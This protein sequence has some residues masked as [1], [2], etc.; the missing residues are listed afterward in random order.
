MW[1]A[2]GERGENFSPGNQGNSRPPARLERSWKGT[3]CDSLEQ[4][5]HGMGSLLVIKECFSSESLNLVQMSSAV[6]SEQ[7]KQESSTRCWGC[8][9]HSAPDASRLTGNVG[10]AFG[11]RKWHLGFVLFVLS[12]LPSSIKGVHCTTL[13]SG[14]GVEG[15]KHSTLFLIFF[16]LRETPWI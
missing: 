4:K 16:L 11:C 13:W 15:K 5:M 10:C 8:S 3:L 9:S 6:A 14:F 12:A 1:A 2:G 7:G